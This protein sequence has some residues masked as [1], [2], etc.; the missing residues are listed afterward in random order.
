MKKKLMIIFGTRPE[1]IKLAPIILKCKEGISLDIRICITG[2]HNEMLR[3]VLDFFKIIPDYDI[4]IMKSN[5]SLFD[6]TIDILRGLEKVLLTEKPDLIIIQG[7]ATSAFVGALAAFYLK[8]PIAHVE[9]GLRSF[10]KYAPFPEEINRILISHMTDYH[11]APTMKAKENLLKEGIDREKIYVVGNTVI[12]TL[13]I[14]LR[15]LKNQETSFSNVF[16]YID[17]EKPLILVTSHRR[18]NFGKPLKSIC[19]ALKEIA[20]K[21]SVEI[22][23]PVHLNPNVRRTVF[24]LLKGHSNIHLISPLDYP[25]FVWLMKKSYLIL[26]DSGGIQE[27]APSLGKPILVLREVTERV[28]GMETGNCKVIGTNR[29][30]IVEETMRLLWDKKEYEKMSK[31]KSPYGDGKSSDRIL[32]I[33]KEVLY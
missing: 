13:Y 4:H 25:Q 19:E 33:L 3:Q 1:A 16:H 18:E 11:F 17:S 32:N 30:R 8:I 21:N 15:M 14:T 7:D 9:A 12:D 26:T 31:I 22:I 6:I 29:K 10:H 20:N 24:D 23:Y 5:Q 27:E 28:E 2:Q